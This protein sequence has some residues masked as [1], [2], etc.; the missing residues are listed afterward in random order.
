MVRIVKPAQKSSV[1]SGFI[2]VIIS[3]SP[4]DILKMSIMFMRKGGSP[5]VYWLFSRVLTV[6]L[7]RITQIE[8]IKRKNLRSRMTLASI[9]TRGEN[10]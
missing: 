9:N 1:Y 5:Y 4:N 2:L 6:K 8:K 7:N 10:C 3:K